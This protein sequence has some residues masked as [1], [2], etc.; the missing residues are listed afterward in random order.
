MDA[1]KVFLDYAGRYDRTNGKIELKI[2]HTLAVAEV[3]DRLTEALGL[4]ERMRELAHGCAVFHDIGRFEQVKRYD[5]FL[6]HLSVDHAAL[7]CA[8]L[9]EEGILKELGERERRMVLTAVGNHNRFRIE[10][11][12]DEET[13]LLCRLI[14]DADKCD[15]FRVFACEDMVDTMGET[16]EQVEKETVSDVVL[17]GILRHQSI[18]KEVRRTG[19]DKWVSFLGFVFDLNFVESMRILRVERYYRRPFERADFREPETRR[20]VAR[21]L[22]EIEQYMDA[23]L[24]QIPAYQTVK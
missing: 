1:E 22:E 17:E 16:V 9:E 11:G 12:L 23:R 2:V 21:I 8:V 3:M 14:R 24:G 5:T 10:E 4:S 15:I 6:D 18:R 19:L 13:L 20:R 7:G